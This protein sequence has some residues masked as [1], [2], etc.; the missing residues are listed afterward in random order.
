MKNPYYDILNQVKDEVMDRNHAWWARQLYHYTNINNAIQILENGCLYSRNYCCDEG[1]MQNDNASSEVISQTDNFVKDY[2]RLYF[3]P[4]TPTQFHNEGYLPKETRRFANAH[5]P[6]P[7]FFAFRSYEVLNQEG[8]KFSNQSLATHRYQ[9][10][11]DVESFKQLDFERIYHDGS[12]SEFSQS[13]K[14][15]ILHKRQAEVI[16][17]RQLSL[18][19][20]D[21]IWCR[22]NAEYTTLVN[23]LKRKGLFDKYKTKIA[24]KNNSMLFYQRGMMVNDVVLNETSIVITIRNANMGKGIKMKA[25]VVVND[26]QYFVTWNITS[27]N[28]YTFDLK[29]ISKQIHNA[30][31]YEV[32]IQFQEDEVYYGTWTEIDELP[33]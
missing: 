22:S 15:D 4:K 11:E 3:R 16:V 30:G 1:L 12:L 17:K 27:E 28:R 31:T 9:I 18:E 33:F 8:V 25:I 20:L 14:D 24:M 29:G 2:V 23:Y 26:I 21:Y 6:V 5:V 7:I 10:Y 19:H 13:D 32:F